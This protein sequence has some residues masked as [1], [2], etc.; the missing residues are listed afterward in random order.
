MRVIAVLRL[1]LLN[2]LLLVCESWRQLWG[3]CL[4]AQGTAFELT[5]IG[6]FTEAVVGGKN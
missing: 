1:Y 4:L 2:S 6:H 3:M 5:S